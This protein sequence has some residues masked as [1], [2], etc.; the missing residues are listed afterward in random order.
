MEAQTKKQVR[1]VPTTLVQLLGSSRF[2]WLNG[3]IFLIAVVYAP[4]TILLMGLLYCEFLA[5]RTPAQKATYSQQEIDV[6]STIEEKLKPIGFRLS[7][8]YEEG[9][10]LKRN[11]DGTFHR[12]SKLG[13]RLND[14]VD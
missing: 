1:N 3:E 9:S 5:M 11:S 6:L 8:I 10:H 7:K 14:E 2:A 4:A 13:V 12:G